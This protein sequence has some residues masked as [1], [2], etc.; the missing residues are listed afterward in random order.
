MNFSA[1]VVTYNED[2]HL[3]RCLASLA[4]CDEIVLVDLGS[5]DRTLEIARKHEVLVLRH[6][7]VPI[8][9]EVR[10]WAIAQARNDWLV[11]LDPDE[12]LPEGLEKVVRERIAADPRLALIRVPYQYYFCGTELRTTGWGVGNYRSA[13]VHRRRAEFPTGVHHGPRPKLGFTKTRLPYER[14]FQIEHRWID[15]YAQYFEKHRRYLS[16]EGQARYDR[17]DRFSYREMTKSVLRAAKMHFV[18]CRGILGGW[19]GLFLSS[20]TSAY[21]ALAWLQLKRYQKTIQRGEVTK[22]EPDRR[23][24]P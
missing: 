5:T 6:T 10:Q 21:I 7:R 23:E 4:F 17:G 14:R 9:E 15:S 20:A 11:L 16:R 24:G 8:I 13:I 19:P 12:I 1:I 3:D 2:R 18:D 22:T